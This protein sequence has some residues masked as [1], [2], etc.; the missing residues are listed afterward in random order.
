MRDAS[1]C[2]AK[3]RLSL[4]ATPQEMT[5]SHS[6]AGGVLCATNGS[7]ATV[8]ERIL[9]RRLHPM[10]KR[11]SASRVFQSVDQRHSGAP[12]L[13]VQQGFAVVQIYADSRGGGSSR[14]LVLAESVYLVR[15]LV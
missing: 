3:R 6:P 14:E 8:G 13:A 9:A 11:I 10:V 1:G 4:T 15:Q 7:A 12:P 5:A 2:T